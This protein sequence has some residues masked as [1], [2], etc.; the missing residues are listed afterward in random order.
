[1]SHVANI[2]QATVLHLI[3]IR[4]IL[5]SKN[6]WLYIQ[7]DGLYKITAATA[8]KLQGSTTTITTLVPDQAAIEG[9]LRRDWQGNS[10]KAA[11]TI[12]LTMTLPSE[13]N[14]LVQL[15]SLHH[16]TFEDASNQL[17]E[18][19][20]RLLSTDVISQGLQ[21][22]SFTSST[23]SLCKICSRRHAQES[24]C[25]CPKA[26]KLHS[27]GNC[28]K[29]PSEQRPDW[30]KQHGYPGPRPVANVAITDHTGAGYGVIGTSFPSRL[31]SQ[32]GPG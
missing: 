8:L 24:C 25:R 11:D 32:R 20:R 15:W 19:Q 16:P 21:L 30:A 17:M 2:L 28:W 29:L 7:S 9:R 5:R 23:T 3:N 10:K 13:Y 27:V 18:H 22:I 26:R 14:L 4:A 1:M 6:G 12:T 31:Q